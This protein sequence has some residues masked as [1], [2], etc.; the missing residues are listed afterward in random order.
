M[1][2]KAYRMELADDI[3]AMLRRRLRQK[4]ASLDEEQ[5]LQQLVKI[6]LE[7]LNDLRGKE[8]F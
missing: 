3:T 6:C 1:Q 2:E 7:V 4:P 5:E 8:A